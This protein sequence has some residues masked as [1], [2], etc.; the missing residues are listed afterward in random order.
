MK[1]EMIHV[2]S[3]MQRSVVSN[4]SYNCKNNNKTVV[5]TLLRRFA[6]RCPHWS[7]IHLFL[8]SK[9]M[10]PPLFIIYQCDEGHEPIHKLNFNNT[11]TKKKRIVP[12][13]DCSHR[14]S[15]SYYDLHQPASGGLLHSLASCHGGPKRVFVANWQRRRQ[16]GEME[17]KRI[18]G[19]REAEGEEMK[20]ASGA[21]GAVLCLHKFGSLSASLT[22][23]RLPHESY[24]TEQA[25]KL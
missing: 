23:I 17:K 15:I 12:I 25:H 24:F 2:E 19:E 5:W 14:S 16:D 13:K 11:S 8:H 6:V 1:L 4:A 20:R 9:L 21:K 3:F 7:S 18:F 22:K 10:R